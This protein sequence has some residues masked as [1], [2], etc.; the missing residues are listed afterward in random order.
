MVLAPSRPAELADILRDAASA[1]HTISLAG[2]STK[3]RMAGPIEP[4]DVAVTTLSLRGVLQYEPR[5]LTIKVGAGRAWRELTSLLA[6]NH[7]MVPLDPPFA[8]QATVGGVIAANASGPRRRLYGTA[9]DVVIGM[10]FA[11]LEG[12]LVEL[13]GVDEF[14]EHDGVLVQPRCATAEHSGQRPDRCAQHDHSN[15]GDQE[16]RTALLGNCHRCGS[17]MAFS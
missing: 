17:H 9:R 2:N 5:D 12:K 14:G 15:G 3:R 13:A 8:D 10:Q 11:T 1:G 16:P 6:E 4:A 7:Q